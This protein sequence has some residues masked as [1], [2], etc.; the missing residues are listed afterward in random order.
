MFMCVH[1]MYM[2]E[3]EMYMYVH[4]M[5]MCLDWMYICVHWMYM[6]VHEMY[7]WCNEMLSQEKMFTKIAYR[8]TSSCWRLTSNVDWA[9]DLDV[10]GAGVLFEVDLALDGARALVAVWEVGHGG[11]WTLVTKSDSVVILIPQGMSESGGWG[12][13][14]SEKFHFLCFLRIWVTIQKIGRFLSHGKCCRGRTVGGPF[15]G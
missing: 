12:N 4:G 10:T 15:S 2:C 3:H 8:L 7:I 5:Y 13:E 1:G 6:F 9:I 11:D 14:K